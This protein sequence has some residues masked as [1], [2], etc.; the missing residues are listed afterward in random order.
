M[1]KHLGGFKEEAEAKFNE[2]ALDKYDFKRCQRAD[3]TFYG[4]GGQ[5]R[6]GTEAGDKEKPEKKERK[7]K[8]KGEGGGKTS[9]AAKKK[10]LAAG[11]AALEDIKNVATGGGDYDQDMEMQVMD[12]AREIF[13]ELDG[14]ETPEDMGW[15]SGFAQQIQDR[16]DAGEINDEDDAGSMAFEILEQSGRNAI[17]QAFEIATNGRDLNKELAKAR[18]DLIKGGMSKEEAEDATDYDSLGLF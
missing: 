4:T 13:E 7:K 14:G 2:L 1:N 10:A 8:A 6:K 3:G 15:L 12:V 11:Q 5:C 9:E 17:P 16:M 18:K